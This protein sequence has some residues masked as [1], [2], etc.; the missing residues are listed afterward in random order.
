MKNHLKRLAAPKQ[1]VL[2]RQIRKY[3]VKP[4]PG[5]HSLENGFALG[6]ILRDL[7][8]IGSRMDEVKKILAT[9]DVLVDGVRRRD[10]RFMV[11][12]FDVVSIP[13]FGK[14]YRVTLD[15]KGRLTL[16]EVSEAE[17]TIKVVKVV[18]KSV[19]SGGKVQFHLHDGRNVLSEVKAAVGDSFVI[20]LPK[21]T[22][23]EVLP[24]KKGS[25]VFL[26]AGKHGGQVGV[27][28]ELTVDQASY[29]SKNKKVTTS[30]DYLLVVGSN[31]KSV[32]TVVP[33]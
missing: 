25:F 29:S 21:F 3:V 31:G 30:R 19:V 11:G 7:L 15:L 17:A 14:Y 5:T 33:T 26:R 16:V 20:T 2:D 32:C 22:I 8:Y 12:L 1:W 4:S 27:V 6:F 10:H 9:A 23:K 24:L 28:D 18:G 13:H